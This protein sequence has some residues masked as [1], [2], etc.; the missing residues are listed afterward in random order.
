MRMVSFDSS[1]EK[2][3]FNI[4]LFKTY[5]CWNNLVC[6]KKCRPEIIET[7]SA[8]GSNFIR[9]VSKALCFHCRFS[10]QFYHATWIYEFHFKLKNVWAC[11]TH[12][13]L[14]KKSLIGLFLREMG[15]LFW[16][17]THIE[18]PLCVAWKLDLFAWGG[19]KSCCLSNMAIKTL[20]SVLYTFYNVSL[21]KQSRS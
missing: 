11:L 19:A 17:E 18:A 1:F 14:V 12:L 5:K 4:G 15:K 21:F 16:C 8:V 9:K 10:A 3:Q 6:F 20:L 13:Y 7:H 2:T